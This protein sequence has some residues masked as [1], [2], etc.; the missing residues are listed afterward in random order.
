M[1]VHGFS[2]QEIIGERSQDKAEKLKDMCTQIDFSDDD[3]YA[4]ANN[5]QIQES[6][7]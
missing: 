1:K 3:L 7:I 5:G 2:N 4:D 6:Q